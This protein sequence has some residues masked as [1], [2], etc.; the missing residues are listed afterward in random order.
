MTKEC[1]S[2]RVNVTMYK[3]LVG[4]L[5]YLTHNRTDIAFLHRLVSRFIQDLKESH[6]NSAK[7]IV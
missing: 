6:L 4:N 1:D 5:I 7:R 3:Q 2:M